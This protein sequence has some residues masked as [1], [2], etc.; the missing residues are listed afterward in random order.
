MSKDSLAEQAM[1]QTCETCGTIWAANEFLPCP[2]CNKGALAGKCLN[3]DAEIELSNSGCMDLLIKQKAKETKLLAVIEVMSE[4]LE[5]IE[6][7][8]KR[9]HKEPDKYTEVGC[10]MNMATE[11]IANAV[12]LLK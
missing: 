5:K 7:P 10:M 6:D 1:Q 4:A 9:D 3:C 8:R 11:A 2:K 12:E